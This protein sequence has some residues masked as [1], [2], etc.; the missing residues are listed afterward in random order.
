M[1][2]VDERIVIDHPCHGANK[3][4]SSAI[5]L[6]DSYTSLVVEVIKAKNK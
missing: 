6:I 5:I 3:F 1:L 2:D 4:M